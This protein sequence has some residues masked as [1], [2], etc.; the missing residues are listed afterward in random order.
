VKVSVDMEHSLTSKLGGIEVELSYAEAVNLTMALL[1]PRASAAIIGGEG[2][3]VKFKVSRPGAVPVPET[4]GPPLGNGCA[5]KIT[6]ADD[7]WATHPAA[8]AKGAAP[9]DLWPSVN[10]FGSQPCTASSKPQGAVKST[11]KPPT[12][13]DVLTALLLRLEAMV[14]TGDPADVRDLA[15][16]YEALSAAESDKVRAVGETFADLTELL[17]SRGVRQTGL[18]IFAGASS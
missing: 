11:A 5:P 17:R 9:E 2:L 16:A 1:N 3:T 4:K 15:E 18:G 13:P 6:W 7:P 14:A 8:P 10:P 12:V